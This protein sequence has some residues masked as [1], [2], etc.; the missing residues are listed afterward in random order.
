[1]TKATTGIR[2]AL[3]YI[4]RVMCFF[5]HN[6]LAWYGTEL[7]YFPTMEVFFQCLYCSEICTPTTDRRALCCMGSPMIPILHTSTMRI[8]VSI[9]GF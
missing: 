8:S 5:T 7:L 3:I 4:M 6:I 1:M 2:D 9:D